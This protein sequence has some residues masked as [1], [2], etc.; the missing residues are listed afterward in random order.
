MVEVRKCELW[1]QRN[2]VRCDQWLFTFDSIFPFCRCNGAA[3][4]RRSIQWND[5]GQGICILERIR[6]RLTF[7]STEFRVLFL[8]L[9]TKY[10]AWYTEWIPFLC[11]W[12][13]CHVISI[14]VKRIKAAVAKPH[15]SWLFWRPYSR[16]QVSTSHW[17]P[18]NGNCCRINRL[19]QTWML[20]TT[21]IKMISE[22]SWN[23]K[24]VGE[25]LRS[26]IIDLRH[27]QTK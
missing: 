7:M 4:F 1:R 22:W 3:A 11:K 12:F 25:L 5:D 27:K 24:L 20:K 14:G 2:D 23:W 16:Y 10:A 15:D 26:V 18:I 19:P 13:A 21:T 9:C 17:H 6:C 8:L